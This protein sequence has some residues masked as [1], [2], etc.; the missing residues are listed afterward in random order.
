MVTIKIN[1]IC[2]EKKCKFEYQVDDNKPIMLE[3]TGL[4]I[5]IGQLINKMGE[6]R[7]E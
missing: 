6:R 5:S 3:K 7:I 4:R 1:P 2:D